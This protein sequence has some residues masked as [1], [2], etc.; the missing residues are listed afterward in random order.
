M[1]KSGKRSLQRGRNWIGQRQTPKIDACKS[2]SHALTPA[3]L[4]FMSCPCSLF[5]G[6]NKLPD[7]TAADPM[8]K[9]TSP[10]PQITACLLA[11]R[12]PT[13]IKTNNALGP[14]AK[15]PLRIYRAGGT[16][17]ESESI[18]WP[19]ADGS[20]YGLVIGEGNEP[21]LTS[22]DKSAWRREQDRS[23]GPETKRGNEWAGFGKDKFSWGH[24]LKC[25]EFGER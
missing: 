24:C 19:G 7:L 18:N 17:W 5:M 9:V 20:V 21:F 3:A 1:K 12:T 10:P 6:N 11:A 15:W 8:M 16:P 13:P 23:K 25:T 22:C 2:S 4:H 14:W